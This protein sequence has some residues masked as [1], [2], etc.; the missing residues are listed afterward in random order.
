MPPN[1]RT[2]KEADYEGE[3]ETTAWEDNG[4]GG[5]VEVTRRNNGTS[6]VHQGGPCGD[7]D[8]DEF[9]EDC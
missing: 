9:G 8:Y 1:F 6:T 5:K 4:I 3:Y 7:Q 2:E